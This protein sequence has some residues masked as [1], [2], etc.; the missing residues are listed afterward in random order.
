MYPGK[1]RQ[2]RV[3]A[4]SLVTVLCLA[5]LLQVSTIISSSRSSVPPGR[6]AREASE[7]SAGIGSS[8]QSE[9]YPLLGEMNRLFVPGPAD[10]VAARVLADTTDGKTASIV[11]MLS[12]QAD[13]SSAYDMKD[14]D[15]RGWYVYNTLTQHA[16]QTQVGLKEFLKSEGAS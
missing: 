11:I 14:Q 7:R 15:A 12:D 9:V 10:K 2:F 1:P 6:E 8:Y 4:C 3:Y 13:V 5:G 16:A